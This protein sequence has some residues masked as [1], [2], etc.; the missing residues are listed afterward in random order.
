MT[1][2]RTILK[3]AAA[4]GSL[5]AF[6]AGYAETGRKLVS[7]AWAGEKPRKDLTGNAPEPEY[8][9]DP[10]T[11]EVILNPDQ[12][13]S[14]AQCIGCTTQCGVRVRID[15]RTGKVLRVAGNPYSPMS[16]DPYLPFETSVRDSF[17]AMAQ[18]GEKDGMK[19]R[20]TACGRGNAV[21]QQ[22]D[23][24]RRVLKPLKRVGPRGSG[25]WQ[26]ISFDQLVR[27]VVEG[28][29]LFGEGKVAGLREIRDLKT[30]IDPQAP[31]FGPRANR[32]ALMNC[33]N[34]GRDGLV[35][36]WLKQGFGSNNFVR[37][38]SYC[39][40]AYRSGSG[41]M[42]GDFKA[43]PHAKP[44]FAEAE[45]IL[46]VGTA[47]GNAGNPF[48]RVGNLVAS[49]RADG[50]L[51]YVV[52][53]P[54]L[55]NSQSEASGERVDWLPIRPATDGALAMALMRWMFEN[56]RINTDY[57]AQPSQKA[58]E[59][60]G[61]AS[62]TNATHLVI[63]E[64]DHPRHG[65]FL[66]ASDIGLAFDG[67]AYGEGDPVLVAGD[68]GPVVPDE[69]PAPLFFDDVVEMPAGAVRVATSLSLLRAEA[70]SRSMADYA[71]ITGI[72][73]ARL[74]ALATELTAHGRKAAVNSHGGMMNGSGFYN[75]YALMMLNTL[76][77]NLNLKGGT[78][79][80]GGW[81]PDQKGPRYDLAKFPGM[82][83]AKGVPIGRNI[84]FEK[85][86]EF[87][88]KK[89][90]GK[91]YTAD[92]PWYPNAPG[93]AT[94]WISTAVNGYPYALEALIFRNTNPVYGIPGIEHLMDRLKDPKV[95]PLIISIDP[96]IN[97]SG[98]IADYIV[99]DSV[100]YETWG[101]TQPWGGVAT[102]AT[103]ARWPVIPSKAD[104]TPDGQPIGLES[105][106][107]ATAKA[108]NLPGFGDAAIPDAD[109]KL[110]PLNRAE[111]WFLRGAANVAYVGGSPV[112]DAS[113]DDIALSGVSRIVEDLKAVLTEEE[114]RKAATIYAKG[115]RYENIDKSYKGEKAAHPF[116]APMFVYNET[117]GTFRQA[118][119]GRKMPGTPAWRE[120]EFTNGDK[121][122]AHYPAADWPVQVVSF[123]S[124][125]QNSYS[126]G[127][128]ALRRIVASNPALVGTGLAAQ[129]GLKT[130]DRVRLTT[131]GGSL[132]T[133]VVVRDGVAP[134]VV[135]IMHGFGH[136]A[137][138][139]S[140]IRI[141][142]QVW[143]AD[144][145][146]GAGVLLNDIGMLDPTR[147]TNPGV[148]VDPVSGTAVRHGLPA[149]LTRIA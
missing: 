21:L 57:L 144:E 118:T 138:G 141:D 103:T 81:Y 92:G 56:D 45:F 101:F 73:E 63:T 48:K 67:E 68:E 62:W 119:T 49:A 18:V 51:K 95:I 112:N 60:A 77:G 32:L 15:K 105:F 84:P 93:L 44:D 33:V 16:T 25:Q 117:L 125:L 74:V 46:F 11:G 34:D 98:A 40:G 104:K 39:G 135:A 31:E 128:P 65:H 38:G 70:L 91:P 10:A 6:A 133:V 7:G 108:M 124:P 9:I 52:V 100:M 20:S 30:P 19:F 82:V 86:S 61:E 122:S 146:I 71:N 22:V 126:I 75:A 66:H 27:E 80:S 1:S 54:V 120:P 96:F 50:K 137:F 129:N 3:G 97:E 53:D 43:M 107:I 55:N 145:G 106:L 17:K 149:R 41:A 88:R 130:G 89:A 83:K 64:P 114:W 111:D 58:A 35:L 127:A 136:R 134:G 87:K 2:R 78:M 36:R 76:I 102:K 147:T 4:V 132:E 8:R 85:T 23:N 37:H 123:K 28:G 143:E 13:L 26:T 99:P 90:A 42:F 69:A 72:P 24:P 5:A 131:P 110:H 109:G 94:E 47:P 140:E 59:K 113:D 139:A 14:Y 115:G 148:W 12:Q 79:V 121:V 142:D 29:D 116:K